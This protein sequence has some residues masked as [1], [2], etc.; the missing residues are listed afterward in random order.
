MLAWRCF[1]NVARQVVH[2][3]A[4]SSLM[5]HPTAVTQHIDGVHDWGGRVCMQQLC[6][7]RRAEPLCNDCVPQGKNDQKYNVLIDV[8]YKAFSDAF[9]KSQP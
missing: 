9:R 7:R 2:V 5:P 8:P 1:S 4:G 3:H 6:T